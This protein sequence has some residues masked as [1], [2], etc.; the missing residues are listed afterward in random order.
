MSYFANINPELLQLIPLTAK[1]VLEVGCG[2]AM[3][4]AEYRRRNPKA[5]YVAIEAHGPAAERAAEKVDRLIQGDFEALTDDEIA[6]Q[7][8]F[9]AIV[10]GDVLEHMSDP[11]RVLG[12]LHGML[13]DDGYLILSV[14]NVAHWRALFE[15]MHGRWPS[16][17][18]GLFDRTHLR[19]FTLQSLKDLFARTG[20]AMVK[21][22]PRKFLLTQEQAD[23]WIPALADL[24]E[25]MGIARDDFVR[26]SSTLQYVVVAQKAERRAA[27]QITIRTAIFAPTLMETRTTLPAEYLDSVPGLI[28]TTEVKAITLPKLAPGAPKIV[29]VQRVVP[30]SEARWIEWLAVA[31]RTGWVVISEWDDHPDLLT[32][33]HGVAGETR[34][35]S[36]A[37]SHAVQTS[38]PALAA[39]FRQRNPEVAAFPNAAF[40]LSPLPRRGDAPPK[41]FFGAANREGISQAVARSLSALLADHPEIEF[42]VVHDRAFFDALPTAAK[43][44]HPTLPY[45][46]Y[47]R[48]MGKCDIALLPL[49]G[50]E[51]ELFKSD[52]K[53][54]EAGSRGLAVIASPAVYGDTI[55]HDETGLIVP[56]IAGWAPALKRLIDEPDVRHKM[57]AAAWQE[58]RD[59]RMFADQVDQRHRWYIDLWRRRAELQQDLLARSPDLARLVM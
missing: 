21:G 19:F 52:I 57:A 10:M 38:T 2:E 55:R 22:K 24:A 8:R 23:K 40:T 3:L 35:T 43:T 50:K 16:E 34:W 42:E 28:S 31:I 9:D 11:D 30:V 26:R 44:F 59:H 17:D 14:P 25:R 37:L 41:I 48:I 12:R 32:E 45:D 29:V 49:E 51:S 53:Y 27:E 56:E 1:R 46:D 20:F 13:A 36:I 18:A 47:L 39:L 58:V 7:E 33:I 54:V 5:E 15:L 4:A 6:D